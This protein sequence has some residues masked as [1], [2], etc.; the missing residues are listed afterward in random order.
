LQHSHLIVAVS[1]IRGLSTRVRRERPPEMVVAQDSRVTGNIQYGRTKWTR[2]R[3][4][5]Y[6]F[7]D[8]PRYQKN[9]LFYMPA[10][11]YHVLIYLVLCLTALARE[12]GNVNWLRQFAHYKWGIV[13]FDLHWYADLIGSVGS[14]VLVAEYVLRVWSCV[15]NSKYGGD[16]KQ[17]ENDPALRRII[18]RRG[19]IKYMKEA[20]NLL[21]L[22]ITLAT[23]AAYFVFTGILHMRF[24]IFGRAIHWDKSV[25]AWRLITEIFSKGYRY[26]VPCWAFA[27]ILMALH[28]CAV[29]QCEIYYRMENDTVGA[30]DVDNLGDALW[31]TYVTSMSI[32]YGDFT[33]KTGICRA[34]ST[35][36]GYCSNGLLFSVQTAVALFLVKHIADEA[37]ARQDKKVQNLA[38]K[39]IQAWARFHL[40]RRK[41]PAMDKFTELCCQ[42]LYRA[43]QKIDQQRR[44]AGIMLPA[45]R[46]IKRAKRT[47]LTRQKSGGDAASLASSCALSPHASLPALARK[48]G[49]L[50]NHLHGFFSMTV[51]TA[52]VFGNRGDSVES[53]TR[54]LTD[55]HDYSVT[56]QNT[57]DE[58]FL[59]LH[60][61]RSAISSFS[62]CKTT[63]EEFG[64]LVIMIQFLLFG[65]FKRRF[66][67]TEFR[68]PP[69]KKIQEEQE[70]LAVSVKEVERKF[71]ELV[72]RSEEK[73][74]ENQDLE[75]IMLKL[76]T[77]VGHLAD[78][79]RAIEVL[80]EQ[81]MNNKED[82]M[83]HIDSHDVRKRKMTM[84]EGE[85]RDG[86]IEELVP[87]R[88]HTIM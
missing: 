72:Q 21:E 57:V 76:C 11:L 85:K 33:P 82:G 79:M 68:K 28:S 81:C 26:I 32:G 58:R 56:N 13:D 87:K 43:K 83:L 38:A 71:E 53:E 48:R 22:F 50:P 67:N 34:I 31:F 27:F 30:S 17:T 7:L 2:L 36:F 6:T 5:I 73:E 61:D 64:P 75:T 47:S 80:V 55:E 19:R 15:S 3:A 59:R 54:P 44:I 63:R 41:S 60:N 20:M 74:Q 18:F 84:I 52:A 35:V 37:N 10:V 24:F 51:A 12:V 40:A 4:R 66:R 69:H 39:V 8:H 88:K 49:S 29:Y 25:H 42:K 62:R 70:K 77:T 23:V 65:H 14:F 9:Y 86:S 78:K 1:M 16:H 46:L 45:R